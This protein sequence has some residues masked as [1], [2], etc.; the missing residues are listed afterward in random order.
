MGD[1]MS[2]VNIKDYLEDLDKNISEKEWFLKHENKRIRDS[3]ERSIKSFESKN[4]DLEEL[5]QKNSSKGR[6][7]DQLNKTITYLYKYI[8]LKEEY[9]KEYDSYYGACYYC[10]SGSCD[11]EESNETVIDLELKE[12]SLKYLEDIIFKDKKKERK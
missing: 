1:K 10:D 8:N 9:Q 7:I 5:K 6:K 12:Q 4:K 11:N 3:L 2:L